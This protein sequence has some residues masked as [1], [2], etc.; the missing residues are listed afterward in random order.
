MYWERS[1]SSQPVARA[2]I[3]RLGGEGCFHQGGQVDPWRWQHPPQHTLGTP[4]EQRPQQVAGQHLQSVAGSYRQV[5]GHAT[6]RGQRPPAEPVDRA[7][8]IDIAN[9]GE[10][11][12]Q[13]RHA[14]HV[15]QLQVEAPQRRSL[16]G[17]RE[18]RPP[19]P[20]KGGL[21]DVQRGILV[22]LQPSGGGVP[23]DLQVAWGG[24]DR[25]VDDAKIVVEVQ[26][27]QPQAGQFAPQLV[28][29]DPD[30]GP[31]VGGADRQLQRVQPVGVIR[32][33]LLQPIGVVDDPLDQ[34]RAPVEIRRR[35]GMY[36]EAPQQS[37]LE[38]R[39]QPTDELL[40]SV[41]CVVEVG[42]EVGTKFEIHMVLGHPGGLYGPVQQRLHEPVDCPPQ[43][44]RGPCLWL[45]LG[46]HGPFDHHRRGSS[47]VLLDDLDQFHRRFVV[48]RLV[49]IDEDPHPREGRLR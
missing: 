37:R 27:Q 23:E 35:L 20:F 47:E 48:A 39:F 42:N 25:F 5:H 1:Y 17:S 6:L 29:P 38:E 11:R 43:P 14:G 22:L 21:V 7:N 36:A 8:R 2:W 24:I 28:W 26:H 44:R 30:G 16:H 34:F 10:E 13:C 4:L 19:P 3:G 46:L 18:R 15:V 31:H 32:S 33:V 9:G 12:P 49:V 41:H 45:D 40:G